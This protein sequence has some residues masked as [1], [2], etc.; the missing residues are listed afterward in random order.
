MKYL[1]RKQAIVARCRDCHA[2]GD[3]GFPKSCKE[4]TCPLYPAR[5]SSEIKGYKGLKTMVRAYCLWCCG[6]SQQEVRSCPVKDCPLYIWRPFMTTSEHKWRAA[7]RRA[8]MT[9]EQRKNLANSA[10]RMRLSRLHKK[11]SAEGI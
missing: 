10:N 7:Q 4:K 6:G 11:N 2:T 5:P 8:R 1:S 9:P 3:W